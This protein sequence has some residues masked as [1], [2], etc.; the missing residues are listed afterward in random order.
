MLPPKTTLTRQVGETTTFTLTARGDIEPPAVQTLTVP[1]TVFDR[2]NAQLRP[3]DPSGE[4]DLTYSVDCTVPADSTVTLALRLFN[5]TDSLF[6][7]SSEKGVTEDISYQGRERLPRWDK[8]AA[9]IITCTGASDFVLTLPL[10]S[11]VGD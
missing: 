7:G 3:D 6:E 2:I 5:R 1:Y 9:L 11:V 10:Q 8:D 4:C